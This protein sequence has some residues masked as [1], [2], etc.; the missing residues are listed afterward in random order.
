MERCA[1]D[2]D[3]DREGRACLALAV[4]WAR[5]VVIDETGP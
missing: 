2:D 4:D 1:R 3:E 5:T